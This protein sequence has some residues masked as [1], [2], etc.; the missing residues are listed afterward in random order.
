[1]TPR[2]PQY[3]QSSKIPRT[4]QDQSPTLS[5]T[6]IAS[7]GKA[8]RPRRVA[9]PGRVSFPSRPPRRAIPRKPPA[10]L[11]GCRRIPRSNRCPRD[12]PVGRRS[13]S[14]AFHPAISSSREP[15]TIHR[16]SGAQ[17]HPPRRSPTIRPAQPGE[18]FV[19][20][21]ALRASGQDRN[22]TSRCVSHGNLAICISPGSKDATP[23][24]RGWHLDAR[25]ITAGKT[26]DQKL[27]RIPPP[28]PTSSRSSRFAPKR[29]TS[30]IQR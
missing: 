5:G 13:A 14:G 24:P 27:K 15:A 17:S 12:R 30:S 20:A 28:T 22:L 29:L 21:A 4:G 26:L 23:V 6:R 9:A 7:A 1:M 2:K 10:I 11:P 25:M 18:K 3:P 8:L 19:E 16:A